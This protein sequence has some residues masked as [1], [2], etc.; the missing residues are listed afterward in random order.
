MLT[1]LNV[2]LL[3]LVVALLITL[4]AGVGR[5]PLWPAVL[6]VIVAQLVLLVGPRP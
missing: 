2:E 5:A 4:G 3:L 6:F 1:L